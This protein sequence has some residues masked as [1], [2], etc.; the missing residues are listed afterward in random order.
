MSS[1]SDKS[2]TI[3]PGPAPKESGDV[4]VPERR[5]AQRFP[6]TAAAEVIDLRS[7]ARVAGRSSDLGLGGCYVD[8]L[9][10]FAVGA[11][12]QIRLE[13]DKREMEATGVVTCALV[14]MGMGLSFTNI[15]AEHQAVLKAWIGELSG[16]TPAIPEEVPPKF[17]QGMRATTANDL[18]GFPE[19][20]LPTTATS[21]RQ[22][23]NEL[24]NLMVR[25]KIISDNEAAAL[26]RNL[27]R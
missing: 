16:E 21:N 19:E 26:L 1:Y 13:R 8:T 17:E 24:I 20:S 9:A 2:Q 18:E 7:K 4:G 27:Y 14:S 3:W 15:K 6:F 25:K 23:L 10:P 22:V 12:V 5:I 11:A